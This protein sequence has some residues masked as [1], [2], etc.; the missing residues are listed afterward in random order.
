MENFCLDILKEIP[1]G[2]AY[3]AHY[4]VKS[5]AVADV[6]ASKLLRTTKIAKRIKGLRAK[7][8]GETIADLREAC[9]ISTAIMRAKVS[10]FLDDTGK[11]DKTK[12]D[13]HAIQSI[14]EQLVAG[15]QSIVTKLRLHS[16]LDGLEKLAKL[17]KWYDSGLVF[18]DNRTII[19]NV[20]DKETKEIMEGMAERTKEMEIGGDNV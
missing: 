12:L 6:C 14:D 17:K 2:E 1:A 19:I 3:F 7:A 15:R 10:D 13:S 4:K 18:N 16:P 5:M 11:I 9:Q 8:E 20:K